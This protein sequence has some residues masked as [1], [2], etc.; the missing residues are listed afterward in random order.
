[1]YII[2]RFKCACA[3]LDH[4]YGCWGGESNREIVSFRSCVRAG[5]ARRS[6]VGEREASVGPYRVPKLHL[7]QPLKSEASLEVEASLVRLDV[8]F[9]NK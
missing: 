4:V 3:K 1:M 6:C 5:E 2:C 7:K 8:N 9:D